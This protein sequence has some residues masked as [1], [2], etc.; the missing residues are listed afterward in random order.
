[1][2]VLRA[3]LVDSQRANEEFK[4]RGKTF[5]S[6]PK[7]EKVYRIWDSKLSEWYRSN[8]R[9]I[10]L[11][12]SGAKTTLGFANKYVTPDYVDRYQI[13]TFNLVPEE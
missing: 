10:W 7:Y 8:T 4:N 11:T 3:Q 5:V 2:K 1:M 6:E 9:S 12:L 13:K